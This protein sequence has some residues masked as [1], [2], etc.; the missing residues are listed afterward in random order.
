M[1]HRSFRSTFLLVLFTLTAGTAMAQSPL[2]GTSWRAT[3]LAGK[4]T[5]ALAPTQDPQSAA[6][7]QFEAG[8]VFGS[9]QNAASAHPSGL[10]GTSWQLVK[11]QS[12]D[13]T[14]LTPDDPAKYTIEFAA[15]GQLFA[16]LDCNRGHG[17]WKSTDAGQIEFGPLAMT[18]AQCAAGS[19]HDQIVKQW[20][21]ISFYIV[22]DGHLFLALMADGGIY[23][24]EPVAKRK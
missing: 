21:N 22:K 2:E 18:R 12:S 14:T 20:C 17:T 13:D 19:L 6:H 11:F 3:E 24:F 7:L 10:A 1:Y 23:E 8:R 9:R 15:D 16:R 5:P 4:P